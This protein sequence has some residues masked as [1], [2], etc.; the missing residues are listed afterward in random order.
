[1]Y[2]D[3]FQFYSGGFVDTG[4][5]ANNNQWYILKQIINISNN[6]YDIY[7]NNSMAYAA[8]GMRNTPTNFGRYQAYQGGSGDTGY[9]DDIYVSVLENV[10][11]YQTRN[12]VTLGPEQQQNVT[13][14]GPTNVSLPGASFEV[15]DFNFSTNTYVPFLNQSFNTT[16]ANT[17]LIIMSSM[18]VLRLSG[19][20][21]R[22]VSINV[23][24]DG[25]EIVE[26]VV[27]TVTTLDEGATGTIPTIFNVSSGQH[28]LVMEVK[29]SGG[30][31]G[32]Q[33]QLNDIDVVLGEFLSTAGNS[34][35]GQNNT[36]SATCDSL[37]LQDAYNWTVN[38]TVNSSTFT[39]ANLNVNASGAVDIFARFR[40]I[41]NLEAGA[42]AGRRL[43]SGVDVGSMSLGHLESPME[44]GIH[45]HSIQCF[46][47]DAETVTMSGTVL[48]VDMADSAN[49][50]VVNFNASNPN[51][52]ITNNVTYSA[53]NHT[54]LNVSLVNRNGTGT[55]L[56][57]TSTFKSNTGAQ[58]PTLKI[59]STNSSINC[60]SK[61]ERYLATNLDIGNAFIYTIC[62][63]QDDGVNYTYQLWI[64]VP[65]GEEVIMLDEEVDGFAA[66]TL[67]IE[68]GDL[69]P[70]P[71]VI[72]TPS[73]NES[74]RG[75]YNVT[76]AP[77]S[78]PNNGIDK[79]NISVVYRGNLSTV[80]NFN[81]STEETYAI[82]NT[83]NLT[84]GIYTMKVTAND[85]TGLVSEPSYVNFTSDNTPPSVED[86]QPVDGTEF[87]TY[88][89][90]FSWNCTDDWS[91]IGN[92]NILYLDDVDNVTNIDCTNSTLCSSQISG[93]SCGSHNFTVECV[94]SAGNR[95]NSSP[96]GITSQ[97]VLTYVEGQ[98]TANNS[99]IA[100]GSTVTF[101]VNSTCGPNASKFQIDSTNE[102][103]PFNVSGTVNEFQI[104]LTNYVLD[105][106][107]DETNYTFT[108]FVNDTQNISYSG[109]E[110]F[111]RSAIPSLLSKI[112]LMSVGILTIGVSA[113]QSWKRIKTGGGRGN[114]RRGR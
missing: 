14:T 104:N 51:T 41:D 56:F 100:N 42:Y 71:N 109:P 108:P 8:A 89:L 80:W 97:A 5:Q 66:G 111:I 87:D 110:R 52:N 75:Q 67:A 90:T 33:M 82:L 94:D 43:S 63:G 15:N 76:W 48:D 103:A 38:K 9:L 26:G 22:T 62:T 107:A 70:I 99:V 60:S 78:D 83:T 37:S 21:T 36:V 79:Y 20:A 69:P 88:N 68:E 7:I 23:S 91:S 49:N 4:V 53:G 72:L 101:I 11:I 86:V 77:F 45:N 85:S 95:G 64:D 31:S 114:Y 13:P 84:D 29:R 12:V 50:T 35:R 105:S 57:V 10:T 113:Y 2:L 40:D 102:T 61:K 58:T 96:N 32:D 92:T 34:V 6:T 19:A 73:E 27:R 112:L 106:D 81:S 28:F 55:F 17:N 30:V 74:I 65:A 46:V 44:L 25:Q 47:T 3:S 54:V 98:S 1:M 18:N 59:N 93:F 24:V 16:A 39:L